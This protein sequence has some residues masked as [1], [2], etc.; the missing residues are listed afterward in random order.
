MITIFIIIIYWVLVSWLAWY[1]DKISRIKKLKRTVELRLGR[2][3]DNMKWISYD[4][5]GFDE[6]EMVIRFELDRLI[7]DGLIKPIKE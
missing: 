3:L 2:K 6:L 1:V 7:K 4:K 5:Q